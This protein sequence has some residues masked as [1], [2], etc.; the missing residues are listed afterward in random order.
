MQE[1][2]Y[3]YWEHFEYTKVVTLIICTII[4]THLGVYVVK[5]SEENPISFQ[6]RKQDNKSL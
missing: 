2:T 1:N 4:N 3:L 5:N 6:N